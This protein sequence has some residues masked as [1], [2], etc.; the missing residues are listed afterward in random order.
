[1]I[2]SHS[3]TWEPKKLKDLQL[4]CMSSS[5]SPYFMGRRGAGWAVFVDRLSKLWVLERVTIWGWVNGKSHSIHASQK[6]IY[7]QEHPPFDPHSTSVAI[8]YSGSNCAVWVRV[9]SGNKPANTRA[10][11]ALLRHVSGTLYICISGPPVE[12][13]HKSKVG[14]ISVRYL[15]SCIP[16]PTS[17]KLYWG[18]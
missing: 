12:L 2:Y 1:M 6:L 4:L 5:C 3:N 18:K 16:L 14:Y 13:I 17:V 8:G 9:L 15:V 7:S 10:S 11:T